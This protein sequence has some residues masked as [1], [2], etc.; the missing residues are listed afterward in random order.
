MRLGVTV[1][2]DGKGKW[3]TLA[4]PDTPIHEQKEMLKK[5]KV[6]GGGDLVKGI[7]LTTNGPGKRYRFASDYVEE[8]AKLPVGKP[9]PKDVDMVKLVKTRLG[10]IKSAKAKNKKGEGKSAKAEITLD[11]AQA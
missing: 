5:L 8:A 10:Q 2:M 4:L 7:L 11:D 3:K 9:R 1:A 6:K